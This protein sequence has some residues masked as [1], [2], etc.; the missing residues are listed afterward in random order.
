VHKLNLGFFVLCTF[1]HAA[2]SYSQEKPP[3]RRFT[4]SKTTSEIKIDGHISDAE[5]SGAT[6]VDLPYEWFPGENVP[7]PVKTECLVTYDDYH[8]YV[9]FR[10][11]DPEPHKIRA[12]L[13]D[14]DQILTLVQDDFVGFMLDTFNDQRRAYQFRINPLGVQAEAL[15]SLTGEDWQWN[16]IWDSA[17]K[18]T[19][20]G[21]SV[22]V[23]LPFNQLRFPPG[24]ESLTFG[25][26]AMRS[27]PRSVRHRMKSEFTDFD[28]TCYLC[29][30]NRISG[31][32]HLSPGRNI[33]IDPTLVS[34][35]TDE[36]KSPD[37][38][39]E[40]GDIDVDPGLTARWGMTPNLTLTGTVNPDFS[41]VE[42]DVAQLEVNERFALF[43][44]ETRP[45]FLEDIDRFQSPLNVVFTRT[46]ADPK[47]GAK[48]TG[49]VGANNLGVFVTRDRIN[50]LVIPS[51]QFSHFDSLE[52]DVTGSVFRYRRDVGR[53]S[54]IGAIYTG[55][56]A[57]GYHNRVAGLD[58]VIQLASADSIDLQFL[59][60]A[61]L[62]PKEVA[63]RQGQNFDDFRGHAV[64]VDYVHNTRHWI[65]AASYEDFSPGFRADFGF[66]PR[67]DTR[68]VEATIA[69]TWWSEG[70]SRWVSFQ[71]GGG[72]GRTVD[73]DGTLTDQNVELVAFY[74]GPL[75]SIFFIR[76][77]AEKEFFNGETFDLNR[78]FF[79]FEMQPGGAAKLRF[80][81]IVGDEIDTFNTQKGDLLNLRPGV[82]LKLG[83]HINVDL[84][85]SLQRLDVEGG[86]LFEENLS[87]AR[88]YYYHNVR[89]LVRLITQYRIIERNPDLFPSPVEPKLDRLFLQFLFSY[90]VNP[91]TVFF[92][93]YSDNY[94]GEQN[95]GLTQTSRTFFLKIGYAWTM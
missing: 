86:R 82:E 32:Q 20:E 62:Y 18:V 36:R 2:L 30:F 9:G 8:L 4:V 78:A 66:V 93:G 74:R 42:A 56:E 90:K 83:K 89:T 15:N 84:S 63:E 16:I 29:Q 88:I 12:H 27:W 39:L 79:Q 6:V 21:Y 49:K 87:E 48:L 59:R 75:Q 55:R 71:F 38:D 81:G 91:R 51:N 53:A 72:Y 14:R 54:A 1:F 95:R 64:S 69:R 7:P 77:A 44:P 47:W 67:V 11:H 57:D 80:A 3:L 73:Y 50:N 5:W 65:W 92:A 70:S 24:D 94:M 40:N 43:F 10:A 58:A 37:G 61:T 35:R 31:F 68:T 17:G 85:H 19:D 23:A 45:F 22:E 33:E 41:Q 46:V 28:D 26:S 34:S 76:P 52:Q 13:M 60:S 25:F